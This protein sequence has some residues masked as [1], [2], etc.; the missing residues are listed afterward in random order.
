MVE[1]FEEVSALVDKRVR[2]TTP[3]IVVKADSQGDLLDSVGEA[4]VT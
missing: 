1:V 3:A 4:K 2:F